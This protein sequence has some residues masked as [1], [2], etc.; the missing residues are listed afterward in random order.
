M[1][2]SEPVRSCAGSG[3]FYAALACGRFFV[4]NENCA[5]FFGRMSLVYVTEKYREM[6][7]LLCRRVT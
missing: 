7:A 6:A 1:T 2:L 4:Y 5:V 3:S